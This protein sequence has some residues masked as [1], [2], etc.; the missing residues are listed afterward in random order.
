MAICEICGKEFDK[1]KRRNTSTHNLCSNKCKYIFLGD[2]NRKHA[3]SYKTPLYGVWKSLRQRCTNSNDPSYKNYGGRGITICDEWND[4]SNF[5]KWSMENGYSDEKLPSGRN[6]LSID[7]ID[8]NGNYEPSNCRWADDYTQ[9]RNKRDSVPEE[10]KQRVCQVCGKKFTVKQRQDIGKTCSRKCNFILYKINHREKTKDMYKKTCPICGKVFE[11]RSGHFKERVCCS[12]KCGNLH[13]SPIW[14][15]NGEQLRVV[16]WGEKV[17]MTAHCLLHRV[18]MGWTIEET[19][20]VP[21]GGKRKDYE[22]Y[23]L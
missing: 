2:M 22:K 9:S 18:E 12:R 17:N 8:V 15:F 6:K 16:E 5:Y 10:E 19:L 3:Y 11:D 1:S 13:K 7:R 21:K 14:E 4:F 20:T 23:K